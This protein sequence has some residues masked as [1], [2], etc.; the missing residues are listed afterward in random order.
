[1]GEERGHAMKLIK[2]QN[3][4]GGRVVFQEIAKPVAQEWSSALH[5]VE[6]QLDLEQT[7]HKALLELHKCADSHGDA[8]LCDFIEGEYLQEQVTA[9]KEVGDLLTKMK[10]TGSEGLGLHII[11]KELQG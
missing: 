2:Y 4:R 3:M 8:Q 7:V 1:M 6:N 10:R 9:E 5:A 11:D